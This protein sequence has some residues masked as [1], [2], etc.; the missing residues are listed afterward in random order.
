MPLV[1]EMIE[2]EVETGFIKV[3][4]PYVHYV[5]KGT[6]RPG[7]RV[8]EPTP[9]QLADLAQTYPREFGHA[10]EKYEAEHGTVPRA[11]PDTESVAEEAFVAA[12]L[13]LTA[14]EA[15]AKVELLAKIGDLDALAV[16]EQVERER[17]KPRKSV[18][19]ALD[20][21]GFAEG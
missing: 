18:L 4:V 10:L 21:A 5:P 12:Y 7:M 17:A 1:E 11:E 2:Q 15:I 14:E 8:V 6:L 20:A 3:T 16:V 13:E 9:K 19:A